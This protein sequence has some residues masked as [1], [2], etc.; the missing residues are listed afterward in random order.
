MHSTLEVIESTGGDVFDL[1]TL[2]ALKAALNIT[3]STEDVALQASITHWSKVIA[4]EIPRVLALQDLV[5]TFRFGRR[6]PFPRHETPL[7][8]ARAPIDGDLAVTIDGL[9]VDAEDIDID[10]DSGSLWIRKQWSPVC[11]IVVI[12]SAGFDLPDH[13]PA[14][15]TQ[16]CIQAIREARTLTQQGAQDIR[17]VSHGEE[18]VTYYTITQPEAVGGLSASVRDMISGLRRTIL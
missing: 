14:R 6:D 1:V 4:E 15:A 11:T 10:R 5:E 18:T 7:R 3:G 2:D 16:A 13:A 12:Y 17:S 8:L 9:P